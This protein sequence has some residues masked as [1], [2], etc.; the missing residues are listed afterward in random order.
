MNAKD[1]KEKHAKSAPA[2][3]AMSRM[4]TRARVR[5]EAW[6]PRTSRGAKEAQLPL[7][8]LRLNLSSV[9]HCCSL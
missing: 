1:A 7:R 4:A 2:N 5:L 6:P 3:T 8:P 9:H